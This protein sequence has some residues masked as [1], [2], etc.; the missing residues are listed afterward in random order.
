MPPEEVKFNYQVAYK[1]Q[2]GENGKLKEKN[3]ELL[4]YNQSLEKRNKDLNEQYEDQVNKHF[5]VF[6]E[7]EKLKIIITKLLEEKYCKDGD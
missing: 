1:E 7:N 3:E 4:K 5:K 2:L 6:K